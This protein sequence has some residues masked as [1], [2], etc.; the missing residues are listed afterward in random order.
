MEKEEIAS[1]LKYKDTAIR[2]LM[3]I[4]NLSIDTGV[5]SIVINIYKKIYKEQI[6]IDFL[7]CKKTNA[8]Y[9]KLILNN[10]SNIFYC[11]NPL[12]LK[13]FFSSIRN[14]KIFFKNN[15]SEYDIVHLHSPTLA[16][17]TLKYAKKYGIK[18]RIVHSHSTMMSLNKI[19]TLINN[20]LIY[21][22]PKYANYFWACSTEAANFLYGENF[23]KNNH[24]ELIK[25]VV[26]EKKF[27]YN[28]EIVR[29]YKKQYK[30]NDNKIVISHISNFSPI[31]NHFF[32]VEIIKKLINEN[33]NF[34][35][36][37]IG[38]GPT[39]IE[40]EKKLKK[41]G[42][43][44]SCIF[45]GR[46][47]NVQDYLMISDVV[48]LPS[49]R[50]G[51]PVSIVEA[52]AAGLPCIVSESITKEVDAGSVLFL[53]LQVEKWV[54]SLK[55]ARKLPLRERFINK[56]NFNNSSFNLD[57]ESN[58]IEKIYLRMAKMN[59]KKY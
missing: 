4:D 40:V 22:I 53:P 10:G 3:I 29:K 14:I 7:V 15:S 51:L 54:K 23:C 13:T 26:D 34:C 46:V 27:V 31:K 8:S 18:N 12:S 42:I 16:L 35:F 1:S 9:E 59:G 32:I 20:Y 33:K 43:Y 50:E 37:F 39:K 56:K 30:I 57:K 24:I 45:T 48:I 47:K 25:N 19:K 55:K 36:F 2:I 5:A 6:K 49:I 58:R 52:Q 17:F 44:E 21:Q 11:G 28:E 38:D 41:F